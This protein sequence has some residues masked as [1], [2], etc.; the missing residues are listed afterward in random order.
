MSAVRPLRLVVYTVLIGT[1][2][3][4]NNP[5]QLL[6]AAQSDLE[7]DYICFTDNPALSSPTWQFRAF[8]HALLPPEK[9]SRLPKACPARFFADYDYSLYIDN[10]V[11]FKRLPTRADV[12]GAR[13]S[14]F[15]HPWRSSP[16]DEA[17]IGVKSGLDEA[18]VVAAQVNFYATRRPLDSVHTLTAGTVLLRNHH[19]AAV[20]RFGELW[21]Q[22]ILLFSKRDQLSLDLCAAEAGLTVDYFPGDKTSN[23]LFM[24]PV[25]PD[26]KRVQGSF[27]AERYAWLHRDNPAARANPRAHFLA[28]AQAGEK[29]DRPVPWF[30]YAA[31]VAGSGLGARAAP[32]RHLADAI[33]WAMPAPGSG[34]IL[35]A[36]VMSADPL[37]PVLEE[38]T[39]AQTAFSRAL[40]YVGNTDVVTAMVPAEELDAPAPFQAA[41]GKTGFALVLVL[42]VLPQAHPHVLAKFGPLLATG[43]RL[44]L[45]FTGSL[46]AAELA[47]MEAA[48]AGRGSL[49][50]F[51]SRHLLHEKAMPAS[52]V[53]LD[54]ARFSL[55]E[56]S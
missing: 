12:E 54:T 3:A 37:S 34:P 13:F 7:I 26:G 40:R 6:G 46:S 1:K 48:M 49:A 42:G 50:V 30:A 52:V 35:I 43:G 31:D 22:Q 14:A 44:L 41:A 39:A 53:V 20:Q 33:E 45:S 5:L 15:R 51:H 24:W 55:S 18:A 47:R 28:T 32:R 8:D 23:D 19:D 2:E 16:A 27:D 29:F 9:G 11:V 38:L 4:L 21:W 56:S 36:G 17:D 25:L 10:T